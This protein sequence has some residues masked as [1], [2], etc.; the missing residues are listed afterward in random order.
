MS[1]MFVTFSSPLLPM[2]EGCVLWSLD[3]K[4]GV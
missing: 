1:A 3:A 2:D 4:Y